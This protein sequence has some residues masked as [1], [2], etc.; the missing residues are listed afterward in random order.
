MIVF[1]PALPGRSIATNASPVASPKHMSGETRPAL[2]GRTASL[3][4]FGVDRTSDASMSNTTVALI[5]FSNV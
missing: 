3:A 4:C 1:E 5:D 2:I